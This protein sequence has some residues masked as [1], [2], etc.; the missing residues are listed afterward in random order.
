M[1][2][3]SQWSRMTRAVLCTSLLAVLLPSVV[4]IAEAGEAPGGAA[5]EAWNNRAAEARNAVARGDIDLAETSLTHALRLARKFEQPDQRL[6]ISL[7]NLA[8]V[9]SQRQRFA[10]AEPLLKEA[11]TTTVALHGEHHPST[12]ECLFNLSMVQLQ[13]GQLDEA[14]RACERGAAINAVVL[15][16][17]PADFAA[18]LTHVAKQYAK[19]GDA[20]KTETALR[21]SVQL[22]RQQL[23]S[24]HPRVAM[25]LANL[26]TLYRSQHRTDDAE[27]A[28]KQ[29]RSLLSKQSP[30][31]R[32]A[33]A[34]VLNN[35]GQLYQEQQRLTEAESLLQEST[36]LLLDELGSEHP[37]V[38]AARMNLAIMSESLGRNAAAQALLKQALP[39]FRIRLGPDHAWT[40]ECQKRLNEVV[41]EQSAATAVTPAGFQKASDSADESTDSVPSLAAPDSNAEF[42]VARKGRPL[43]LP[44]TIAEVEYSFLLDTG[45]EVTVFDQSLK[46][47]LRFLKRSARAVTADGEQSVALAVPPQFSLRSLPV[48]VPDQ[49]ACVD[50][51]KIREATGQ[52][53]VGV[54]GMD[55]LQHFV[56]DIDFD[57]G[58][59]RV[60]R[61]SPK[62]RLAGLPLSVI[63][64]RLPTV[65]IRLPDGTSEAFIIDTGLGA[66]GMLSEV[67][68]DRLDGKEFVEK[69][70]TSLMTTVSGASR[71][72]T[73]LIAGVKLA[74]F[75]HD[76]LAFDRGAHNMLGLGLLSRYA[77]TFDF[78]AQRLILRRGLRFGVTD[79]RDLS[80][81]HL[82]YVENRMVIASVDQGSASDRAGLRSGDVIVAVDNVP[83]SA[84][85]LFP[86]RERLSRPSSKLVVVYRR[87][88]RIETTALRLAPEE[89]AEPAAPLRLAREQ[90]ETVSGE[91]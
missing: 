37:R 3:N 86:I 89:I 19:S 55:V 32:Q 46:S 18:A 38:A 7:N 45:A 40:K 78:P 76:S 11:L 25:A 31:P 60:S 58:Q 67:A 61:E 42:D 90:P 39:V 22:V 51:S 83:G 4:S 49:V 71:Q 26:A 82:L 2:K 47:H 77:V 33:L 59:V 56:I 29:S 48:P 35:L 72:R 50:L 74:E 64:H 12:A 85:W 65:E 81:L 57:L 79:Q 36:R 66:N 28:L 68:F 54:L 30:V 10:L 75:E 44:V 87:D 17:N 15:M 13:T 1:R 80:G 20:Q 34:L 84:E 73:G 6:V 24:E 88:D 41:A 53:I 43:L 27:A 91:N 9:H 70:S 8:I 5:D 23:G 63:H 21:R 52:P 69:Q 62:T 16:D 14:V